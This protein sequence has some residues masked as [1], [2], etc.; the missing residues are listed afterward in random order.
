ML[1]TLLH[2]SDLDTPGR[3]NGESE[4]GR[5][6]LRR[7]IAVLLGRLAAGPDPAVHR[8]VC[9]ALARSLDAAAR[10]GLADP[11]DILLVVIHSIDDLNAVTAMTEASTQPD[12]RDGLTAYADFL[13]RAAKDPRMPS[14][15]DTSRD[16]AEIGFSRRDEAS[17]AMAVVEL[18]R[19]IGTNGS[20]RGEALRQVVRRMGRALDAVVVARGLSELVELPN[21]STHPLGEI[22]QHVSAFR[23][24]LMGARRR[25][26]EDDG[27]IAID[28]S[29]EVPK[30]S[31]L[32]E[33]AVS[34]IVPTRAEFA[35]SIVELVSELPQVVSAMLSRILARVATLPIAPPS[36]ISVIP[37][38]NRRAEL[39][40]WLLPRRTIGGFYVVR[41][42]GAGGVSS[43]FVAQRIEERRS[44]APELYAL[45]VPYYD[46]NTARSLTESEFLQLFRE[47]AGALLSLPQHENLSRFVTFDLAAKPK[48][49]LVMEL[50]QGT[51]LD[52][53]IRGRSLGTA[54]ALHY[55]DGILAGLEA[56]HGVGVGHLDVKPSNV[57]L[58]DGT[59][60]VLVD[61]GLS[62]RN[63]RPGCGTLDYCAPEVLGAA[64]AHPP[65]P[66]AADIYA[67]GCTAFEVLTGELIFD[68]ADEESLMRHHLSH[69]GWPDRVRQLAQAPGQAD[70]A[71]LLAACLRP[72][73]ED[74]PS[75]S[76]VRSELASVAD[77]LGRATWPLRLTEA[78]NAVTELTA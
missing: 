14:L 43:V 64:S 24:L 40:D 59:T 41:A 20:H 46:P 18:S 45:K 38:E 29:A 65:T 62:G 61:F 12:V 52:R 70:L 54:Q 4:A 32:V 47:E 1:R 37:L 57:I 35:L 31:D 2:L 73:P 26:L 10:D 66:A 58:R 74:R 49:I 50:I 9:A 15:F 42:L 22:E 28:V 16:D 76:H 63:I 27:E 68:A 71:V 60:P 39:P 75:A 33:R 55:L 7:T 13:T 17:D 56:M 78:A 6:R 67:F 53:L 21:G 36:D 3:D 69:D 77:A 5:A 19:G 44:K 51:A 11:G 34:G 72:D 48:P 8:L 23:R 25:V 30:L